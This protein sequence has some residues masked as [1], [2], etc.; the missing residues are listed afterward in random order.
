M[1]AD[2]LVGLVVCVVLL[3]AAQI[4]GVLLLTLGPAWEVLP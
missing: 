1:T 2:P 3:V 4:G